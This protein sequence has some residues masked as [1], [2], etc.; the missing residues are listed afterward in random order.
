MARDGGRRG[1]I[2]V[3]RLL[4]AVPAALLSAMLVRIAFSR[5]LPYALLT[6]AGWLLL[7]P[8]RRQA[9]VAAHP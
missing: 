3:W 2:G 7:G 8:L 4:S 1:H 9:G 5:L 6:A